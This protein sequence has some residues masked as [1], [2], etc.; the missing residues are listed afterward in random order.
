MNKI[1]QRPNKI[2]LTKYTDVLT[3]GKYKGHT[4]KW[5]MRVQPSYLCWLHDEEIANVDWEILNEAM[6]EELEDALDDWMGVDVYG[7]MD[8]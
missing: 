7:F 6:S 1:S 8:D 3:F 5:I 2:S 4:V